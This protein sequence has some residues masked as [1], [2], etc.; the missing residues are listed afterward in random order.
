MAQEAP[1]RLDRKAVLIHAPDLGNVGCLAHVNVI[2]DQTRQKGLITIK[3]DLNLAGRN[4]EYQSIHLNILPQTIVACSI[5]PSSFNNMLPHE[6]MTKL[7]GVS[8]AKSATTLTLQLENSSV[9]L[10]PPGLTES[11]SP[12]N[13]SDSD[14][15]AISQISRAKNIRLHYS[16]QGISTSDQLRLQKFASALTNEKDTTLYS[17]SHSCYLPTKKSFYLVLSLESVHNVRMWHLIQ[18]YILLTPYHHH[19]LLL[20]SALPSKSTCLPEQRILTVLAVTQ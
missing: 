9:V 7:R 10:V 1:W 11:V 12:A 15:Y 17:T 2:H 20:K 16:R 13:P 8:K 5:I 6:L 18:H 3:I 19:V 14:F 4:D